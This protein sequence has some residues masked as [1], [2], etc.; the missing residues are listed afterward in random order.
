MR[1]SAFSKDQVHATNN[2]A[3]FL[4][5]TKGS[6]IV[7]HQIGGKLSSEFALPWAEHEERSTFRHNET[8]F[9]GLWELVP[10]EWETEFDFVSRPRSLGKDPRDMLFADSR[11]K[12]FTFTI[13]RV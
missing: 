2:V 4:S 7:G 5:P 11:G 3:K 6:L 8:S 13:R 12:L 1:Q 9:K 10:G